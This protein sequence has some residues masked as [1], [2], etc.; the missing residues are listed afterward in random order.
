MMFFKSF[1]ELFALNSY[2]GAQVIGE[3]HCRYHFYITPDGKAYQ[4]YPIIN[5]GIWI[6]YTDHKDVTI[7]RPIEYEG[8]YFCCQEQT[9]ILV[10]GL[11]TKRELLQHI[12]KISIYDDKLKPKY[13]EEFL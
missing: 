5:D 6:T 2:F 11:K 12:S 1:L 10:F 4:L 3:E 7:T 13:P 8:L 9:H